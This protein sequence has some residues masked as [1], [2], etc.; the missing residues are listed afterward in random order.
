MNIH[1]EQ[2]QGII[3]LYKDGDSF[4]AKSRY[5]TVMSYFFLTNTAIYIYA[6]RGVIGKDGIKLITNK[7]KKIGVNKILFEKSESWGHPA[8]YQIDDQIYCIDI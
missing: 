2:K 6:A 4:E 1:V 7:L 5:I 3:R 8:E